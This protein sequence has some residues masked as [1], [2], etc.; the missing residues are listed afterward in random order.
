MEFQVEASVFV[1]KKSKKGRK[2][3]IE[4]KNIL[5]NVESPSKKE[6]IT[7]AK[8]SIP[9]ILKDVTKEVVKI[10]RI[11]CKILD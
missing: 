7:T 3:I 8:L 6:A 1:S 11:E 4:M 10:L 2:A 9:S 5:L